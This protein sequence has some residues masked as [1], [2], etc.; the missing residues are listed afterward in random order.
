MAYR[1]EQ[2]Q[3]VRRAYIYDRLTLTAA[4]ERHGVPYQT[5]RRWKSES[6]AA[7][8]CWEKARAASRMAA[9]GLGDITTQ[10]LEDFS[11]LF[12]STIQQLEQ[13]EVDPVD[14]AES[15]ARLADAYTKTMK[16][17]G[18]AEPKVAKLAIAMQV[19][20][21]FAKFIR[22]RN[23]DLL[24]PFTAVLEPFGVRI[25]EVLG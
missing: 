17:A 13:G 15:I 5:V 2:R 16:A 18:T 23:P 25:A 11:R 12:Q 4:A 7:G 1:P 14:K 24:A 21:E 6:E 8:D 19:I 9:G 10:V 22:E 3:A 20:E